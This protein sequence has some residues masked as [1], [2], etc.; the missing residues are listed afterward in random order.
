MHQNL[1]IK[2]RVAP[3]TLVQAL[4]TNK[5]KHFAD[6]E[7]AKAVFFDEVQDE[8]K[9]LLKKA[10][11]ASEL[12]TVHYRKEPPINNEKLYDKYIGMFRMATDETI[13][14]S[15]ED[16]GCIVDDNW[17]WA[18]TASVLNGAYSSKYLG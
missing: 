11:E 4:E 18:L 6:F 3:A 9:K 7:K 13:E 8:L 1:E 12:K 10:K 2:I 16:Y 17:S 14:I 15:S 5:A